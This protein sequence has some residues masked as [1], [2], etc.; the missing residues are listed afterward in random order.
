MSTATLEAPIPR[1]RWSWLWGAK[2]D[3]VWTFAPFWAGAALGLLL[4]ALRGSA[5]GPWPIQPL[6]QSISLAA[7]ILYFYSPLVDAPHLFATVARTYTDPGEWA[8]RRRLFLLSLGWFLIGPLV[9]ILPYVLR[10]TVGFPAGH[11]QVAWLIW[12]RFFEL[13]ALHHIAKQHWGFISLYKR[14]NADTADATENRI[15]AL[16]FKVAIWAPYLCMLTAP[17]Y[18][19][20]DNKP[21]ALLSQPFLGSTLGQYLHAASL[22]GLGLAVTSYVVFQVTRAKRGKARNGPKLAYT[23]TVIAVY[24]LAFCVHPFLALFWVPI[25]GIGH[26]AQ[27]HRVVWA[28]GKTKYS[29]PQEASLPRRIFGNVWLYIALGVLYGIVGLQGPT[30]VALQ[31][32]W[33]ESLHGGV[34]HHFF[35]YLDDQSL[36]VLGFQLCAA[37]A[38]GLRL[39]HFYVDSKIW[40]VSKNAALAKNLSVA[41]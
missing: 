41:T 35:G 11:E 25:T 15:D 5:T 31:K 10:V 24:V 39:H 2:D 37:L 20:F 3:V 30:G 32:R 18:R 36:T 28:Y 22:V 23:A 38:G 16:F 9:I 33:A 4:F 14:K 7:L 27:Y 8:E 13:Y 34:L 26:C 21:F 29:A 17:W 40:R 6:G 12:T 19:D 1:V